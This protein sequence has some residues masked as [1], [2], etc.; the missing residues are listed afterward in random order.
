[1]NRQTE[2]IDEAF[3]ILLVVN[4]FCIKGCNFFIIQGVRR[5]NTSIDDIALIQLQLYITSN[6]LLGF[7]YESSQ[8]FPQRCIPL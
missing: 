1:M 8:S 5:S 3:C 6:S 7:I 4:I 2:Q